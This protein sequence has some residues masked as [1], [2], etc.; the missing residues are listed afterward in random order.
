MDMHICNSVYI[1]TYMCIYINMYTYI[2]IYIYVYTYIYIYIY[3]YVYIYIYVYIY[4]YTHICIYIYIIYTDSNQLKRKYVWWN[5]RLDMLPINLYGMPGWIGTILRRRMSI[6]VGCQPRKL[7]FKQH[8]LFLLRF[9]QENPETSDS[10]SVFTKP[11]D[12]A[13][14]IFQVISFCGSGSK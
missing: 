4:V 1:Y 2:Y 9:H 10:S 11:W 3:V 5:A 12:P 14:G 6:W 7:H 13:L 8:V